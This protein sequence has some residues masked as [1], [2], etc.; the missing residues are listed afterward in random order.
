[1]RN[2]IPLK[3]NLSKVNRHIDVY[4]EKTHFCSCGGRFEDTMS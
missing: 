1:M 3:I 2:P 4:D